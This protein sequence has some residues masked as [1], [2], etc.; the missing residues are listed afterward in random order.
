MKSH[1]NGTLSVFLKN[2]LLGINEYFHTPSRLDINC[3]E[4]PAQDLFPQSSELVN[5]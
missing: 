2:Q 5:I 3:D 1:V 4:L